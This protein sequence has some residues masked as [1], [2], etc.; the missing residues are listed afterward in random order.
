MR[1]LHD[2]GQVEHD[3]GRVE[4]VIPIPDHVVAPRRVYADGEE[5]VL[6]GGRQ[7]VGRLLARA[8]GELTGDP[9][10]AAL[11]ADAIVC[12]VRIL[13]ECNAAGLDAAL[14][15]RLSER[16]VEVADL[17]SRGWSAD[18]SHVDA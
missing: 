14:T 9:V 2:S 8:I 18:V 5:I 1:D 6:R 7:Q 12:A 15:N 17:V 10:I 16:Q 13:G 3:S 4:L 11:D